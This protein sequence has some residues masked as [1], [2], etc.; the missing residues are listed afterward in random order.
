MF[1]MGMGAPEFAI[2]N[3][4]FSGRILLYVAYW[5]SCWLCCRAIP[6]KTFVA[7]SDFLVGLILRDGVGLPEFCR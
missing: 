7:T 1:Y 4:R 6:L 3:A 2:M 5:V